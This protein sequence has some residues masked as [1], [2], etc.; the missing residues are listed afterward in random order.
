MSCGRQAGSQA[1]SHPHAHTHTRTKTQL[2]FYTTFYNGAAAR[3][4]SREMKRDT[5]CSRVHGAAAVGPRPRECAAEKI[6]KD[7]SVGGLRR[8]RI[9]ILKTFGQP[10][11]KT[12]KRRWHEG[13][14]TRRVA[15]GLHRII[16]TY[17][18]EACVRRKTRVY[19]YRGWKRSC[20][21]MLLVHNLRIV[22]YFIRVL[23]YLLLYVRT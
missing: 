13:L 11:R 7:N 9:D 5:S 23:L 2:F 20:P 19:A 16:C 18:Q 8:K 10:G 3:F 22:S 1:G 4:A 15:S 14:L 17:L 21:L 12:C 6:E